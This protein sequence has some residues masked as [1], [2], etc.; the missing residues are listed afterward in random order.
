MAVVFD[1]KKLKVVPIGE[2]LPNP[3]NPKPGARKSKEFQEV[4]KSIKDK[5]LRLPIIVREKGNGYEIVDGEQRFTAAQ[6]LGFKEVVVYNEGKL[7]DQQAKELTIAFQTQVPFSEYDLGRL[8]KELS[9]K[10][11]HYQLP[12]SKEKVAELVGLVD[13]SWNEYVTN[14]LE[15]DDK[16]AKAHETV[17][18]ATKEEIEKIRDTIGIKAEKKGEIVKINRILRFRLERTTQERL[19]KVLKGIMLKKGTRDPNAAFLAL[20]DGVK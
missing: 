12:Y 15:I 4:K 14:F 3:W 2:V 13:F 16:N 19:E 6:D 1:P 10:Y 8:V 11:E 17:F 5:G 18:R 7:S 20:L 9:T